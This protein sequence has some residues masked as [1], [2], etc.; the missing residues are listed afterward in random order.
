MIESILYWARP[1]RWSQGGRVSSHEAVLPFH[2]GEHPVSRHPFHRPHPQSS[3]TR[4]T[5]S[6]SPRKFDHGPDA[7]EEQSAE[8]SGGG[9]TGVRARSPR[10]YSSAI[11]YIG[12]RFVLPAFARREPPI[13]RTSTTPGGA[14]RL[15]DST[16]Q[17]DSFRASTSAHNACHGSRSASGQ[18]SRRSGRASC[19]KGCPCI[20]ATKSARPRG[21]DRCASASS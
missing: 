20:R 6:P 15:R 21:S 11:R 9:E 1:A 2:G 7:S 10:A 14:A 12:M 8:A 18:P 19:S 3:V 13:D 17:G 4:L 16:P 5:R